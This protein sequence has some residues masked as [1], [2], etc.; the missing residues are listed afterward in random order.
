MNFLLGTILRFPVLIQAAGLGLAS[1]A[2]AA[3]SLGFHLGR[4]LDRAEHMASRVGAV[5]QMQVD[6]ILPLWLA[7][8]VPE[9][10][11]G[12]AAWALAG[13]SGL[14]TAA[15]AKKFERIYR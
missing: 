3:V 12:F 13:V 6:Q 1:V 15:A 7:P 2:F 8:F 9:S 14:L 11:W 10:G 4:R 5:I